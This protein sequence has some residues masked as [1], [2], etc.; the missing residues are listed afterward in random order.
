MK[1]M[2]IIPR[3]LFQNHSIHE[4]LSKI[5]TLLNLQ[6]NI[7]DFFLF[8]KLIQVERGRVEVRAPTATKSTFISK[9]AQRNIVNV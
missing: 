8:L 1:V 3:D 7:S 4:V 5:R 6:L 2:Q 9:R